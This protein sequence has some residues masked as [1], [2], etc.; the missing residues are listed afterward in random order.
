VQRYTADRDRLAEQ[1]MVKKRR[2]DENENA[3]V[4]NIE[5]P[6][7]KQWSKSLKKLG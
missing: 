4:T 2:S 5:I 1:A 3:D 6:L 7:H